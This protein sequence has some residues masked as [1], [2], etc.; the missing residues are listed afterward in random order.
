MFHRSTA[1]K[2]YWTL[3]LIFFDFSSRL[4]A[5]SSS[6][7]DDDDSLFF[8]PASSLSLP[9]SCSSPCSW[10]RAAKTAAKSSW[11]AI[12]APSFPYSKEQ[13][14]CLENRESS[15]ARDETEN[16]FFKRTLA[17]TPFFSEL[18]FTVMGSTIPCPVAPR[19]WPLSQP[20]FSRSFCPNFDSSGGKKKQET[21]KNMLDFFKVCAS[22]YIIFLNYQRLTE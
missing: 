7:S 10:F 18:L 16:V 15:V 9:A 8:A 17:P 22:K 2:T 14:R 19:P 1:C 13:K 21:E 12:Q 3:F 4:F 6:F 20:I 11:C 5:L